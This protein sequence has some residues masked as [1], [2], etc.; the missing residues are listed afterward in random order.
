M[1]INQL[2]EHIKSDNLAEAVAFQLS[3]VGYVQV[4]T[5]DCE[6]FR[7]VLGDCGE[8]PMTFPDK[9]IALEYLDNLVKDTLAL[10]TASLQEPASVPSS[11]PAEAQ[12]NTIRKTYEKLPEGD[13]GEVRIELSK[14]TVDKQ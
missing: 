2:I 10:L 6:A 4:K 9:K 3:G 5:R 7:T 11:A 8:M 12:L 14:K 13:L 1:N